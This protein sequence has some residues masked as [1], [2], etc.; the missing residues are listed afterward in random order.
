MPKLGGEL[1]EHH[2]RKTTIV[3]N[4]HVFF[5]GTVQMQK[6]ILSRHLIEKEA[7][8]KRKKRQDGQIGLTADDLGESN[9]EAETEQ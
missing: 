7:A 1:V 3:G 8:K 4:S 2:F 9:P 6:H 5:P